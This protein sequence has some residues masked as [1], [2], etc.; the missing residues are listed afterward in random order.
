ML[1]YAVRF[2]ALSIAL[3]A[4]SANAA[5]QFRM[6]HVA[7]GGHVLRFINALE[8][9]SFGDGP[10]LYTTDGGESWRTATANLAAVTG[11]EG[12]LNGQFVDR[13]TGWAITHKL[14]T[15]D[16][17][18]LYGTTD[19]GITW[20][21]R[22]ASI[23]S[24]IRYAGHTF[25][26]VNFVDRMNGW[27]VGK[28]IIKHTSD[29]GATWEDQLLIPDQ[30]TNTDVF[31]GCFFRSAREGWVCG[32][33]S[34]VLHTE[35]GGRNWTTQHVDSAAVGGIIQHVE[36]YYIYGIH[37]ADALNGMAAANNGAYLFTHDGGT[38]WTTANTGF[39]NDNHAVLM[40]SPREIWMVGGDYCD[41]TGCYSGKSI[42]RSTDGGAGWTSVLDTTV[43]LIG[44]RTQYTGIA[45]VNRRTGYT[46]TEFGTIDRITDTSASEA[47]ISFGAVDG[48]MT[49]GPNPVRTELRLAFADASVT[50]RV[51]V[52]D[53]AGRAAMNVEIGRASEAHI[54]MTGLPPGV[55]VVE[56]TI[57]AMR[58]RRRVVVVR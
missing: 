13:N 17:T 24:P 47:G 31:T 26:S 12:V 51:V 11:C 4:V 35:D 27:I 45:F 6:R 14:Y 32:F 9:Y 18:F 29:G 15:G 16:S 48:A 37:F 22:L 1:R 34:F 8:G 43:G 55:Y 33:G 58:I 25:N 56:A 28:G 38:T 7:E 42:L 40:L 39:V 44:M 2:C 23:V 21:R 30:P 10:V 50:K 53:I 41:N 3:V 46:A 57:G 20:T 5:A 36:H 54:D 52:R 19:G 49:V